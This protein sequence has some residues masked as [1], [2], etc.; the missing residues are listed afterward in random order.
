VYHLYVR[1]VIRTIVACVAVA[2]CAPPACSDADE[3]LARD[4]EIL[5]RDD[6]PL[7]QAARERLVRRGKSAIPVI[8]T[9]LYAAEPPA[10]KR[11]IRA[12]GEIGAPE[13]A[14]ILVHLARRDP[15]PEVR[16]AAERALHWLP[17]RPKAEPSSGNWSP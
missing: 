4:V 11:I 16:E 8:E 6:G 7:G 1:S 13:A 14:P 2:G 9:G 3:Q 10:R 17:L 15:D 5:V 12:L